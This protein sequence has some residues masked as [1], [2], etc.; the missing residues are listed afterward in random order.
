[1]GYFG[2][3]TSNYLI[4][5]QHI[6]SLIDDLPLQ[7]KKSVERPLIT[8]SLKSKMGPSEEA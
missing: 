1:M 7:T 6:C 5:K 2:Y 4:P 3:Y 8:D